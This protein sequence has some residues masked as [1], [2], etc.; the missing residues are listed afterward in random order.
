MR[1][2]ENP[3][4]HRCA[5]PALFMTAISLWP[6]RAVA[7]ASTANLSVLLTDASGAQIPQARLVL[8]NVDTNQEQV[9]ES[10]KSGVASFSFLKPGHYTL[11]V[12]KAAFA[13]V[14]V[15]RI[16]LNV[17]DDKRVQLSLKIGVA[18]QGITVDGSG[19][20][21]NTTDASVGTVIDRKFVENIPLNGR[22]FQD[23]ISMT[24]G[25]VTQSPQTSS[26]VGYRGD[27]S[28]NGQRTE[29]NYYTVD[30]VSAASSA[31]YPTG[32]AQA[33]TGGT[34]A[35]S[36]TLGTT[37]SLLGVDAMQEFRVQSSTYSAEF[38]RGPGGQF[39]L[40]TRSGSSRYHGTA[41]DYLRNN[42]FDANDWFNNHYG[43]P[44]Q[45][46]RQNDFGGTLGGPILPHYKGEHP[47]FYFFSYEG[48]RLTA[49]QAASIQ[50]VPNNSV[51][52]TAAP[53]IK[54]I[55]N[56]YP[57]PTVGGIDYGS[58][59]QFI[60]GYSVPGRIDSFSVRGDQ[61]LASNLTAFF[62]WGRTLSSTST[63]SLS[64]VQS[65]TQATNSYTAGMTW[66][67]APH[68]T[69]EL[70]FG[71]T[72]GDVSSQ[73]RLD[74]FGG[75]VPINLRNAMG[76]LTTDTA[77]ASVN[78]YFVG[79]GAAALT[80]LTSRNSNSQWNIVDT[81]SLSTGHHQIRVGV[82]YRRISAPLRP[83][84]PYVFAQLS[85][86]QSLV[87]GNAPTLLVKKSLPATPTFNE[88]A[89]FIQDE[90]RL[91]Q[92]LTVSSGLRW[93]LAPP[94]KNTDG[95]NAFTLLGSIGDPTRLSVAPQGTSLWSTSHYNFA[96]RLGAAWQVIQTPGWETILRAGGGVFF[97]TDNSIA[98][99]GFSGLGFSTT[100][101][102]NGS[103]IPVS[104]AQ[105]NFDISVA[106]PYASASIYAFPAHLQLPYTLQWNAAL[107]QALSRKQS[108]TIS[109]VASNGRRLL[110]S[111]SQ[112][113]TSSN[114]QFGIVYYF[115][116][117]VTSNYQSLQI[118]F[119]RSV[120]SG[121]Q[122]LSSYTWAHS[123]DL[124]SNNTSAPLSRG[125]SD[126]D[127]RQ[128]F[129]AGLTWSLPSSHLNRIVDGLLSDWALDGRL[130]SRSAFP[131]TLQGN[132]VTDPILGN[133]TTNVNI[134]PG[135]PLYL[136]GANYAGGRSVNRAAFALPALGSPGNA[137]RNF[138]RAFGAGQMNLAVRRDFS[139]REAFSLQFRAEAFNLLNHPV[140]GY[141]DPSLTSAT[142]GQAT[143]TLAQSL[144]TMSASY[145]QGGP[146][147]L[148]FALK[149][150]F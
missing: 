92:R 47:S 49:P 146:R 48:L 41:F 11:T 75:A 95:P 109:Y 93:E 27:F 20:T 64:S 97:D 104:A 91:N 32:G 46:L 82:D 85:T 19:L 94:P 148:Q 57:L 68:F 67:M 63:R 9:A 113:L 144:G 100:K 139:L 18:E 4:F 28:V 147:S 16:S 101:S 58:L 22:S 2:I 45:A 29:S 90:W 127:V 38:G 137:P 123:I 149:L 103:P 13:D 12:S 121:L 25:V 141:V 89:A 50:Y 88:F 112:N 14:V 131:I 31:G 115:P 69:D 3:F 130:N 108:V 52:Q 120:I 30:G 39:S 150:K 53:A 145:Q 33:A 106:P 60:A 44:I 76:L 24:S 23:L 15:N 111:R 70:R 5:M 51:R 6:M 129:Q 143:K 99:G 116:T 81:A 37:Q 118:K 35:S 84:S 1:K 21:M 56:A 78:L 80:E 79:V 71:Y 110:Q 61:T 135:Q 96:P 114:P 26:N 55:L 133:Y 17:G 62:R 8:R 7:D 125:N 98:S 36:T 122:V 138:L 43:K 126:F 87:T 134:V 83:A 59:A 132:T 107:E 105:Q 73:A 66:Q 40:L 72:A 128:N 86:T 10:G 142:F 136:N 117:G 124:G 102:Y 54:P 34:I 119:Q 42:F 77:Y 74:G 65:I 140:F